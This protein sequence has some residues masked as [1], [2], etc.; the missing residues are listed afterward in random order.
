VFTGAET[1]ATT[2]ETTAGTGETTAETAAIDPS[3][4]AV[5]SL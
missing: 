4:C 1:D 2:A 5:V 3:R